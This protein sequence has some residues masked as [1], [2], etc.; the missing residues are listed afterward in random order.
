MIKKLKRRIIIIT[1]SLVGSLLLVAFILFNIFMY[2]QQAS[3]L[4]RSLSY[5]TNVF[6]R[7][8]FPESFDE[9]DKSP[10]PSQG[11]NEPPNLESSE[12]MPRVFPLSVL[13]DEKGQ[14]K[15]I[16]DNRVKVAQSCPTL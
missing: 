7:D 8:R 13:L 3:E 11:G 4:E 9:P 6:N 12:Q 1:M 14:I 16:F 2:N 10:P 5:A 15:E